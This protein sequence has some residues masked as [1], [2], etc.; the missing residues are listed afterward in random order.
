MMPL[1]KRRGA[2]LM[3]T[4]VLLALLSVSV[5]VSVVALSSSRVQAKRQL[6]RVQARWLAEANVQQVIAHHLGHP[7]TTQPTSAPTDTLFVPHAQV[8]RTLTRDGQ[9]VTVT[10][11]VRIDDRSTV[12]VALTAELLLEPGRARITAWREK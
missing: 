9:N 1:V 2:A 11:D 7:P 10:C 5:G 6:A 12:R 8:S 3:V 4:L